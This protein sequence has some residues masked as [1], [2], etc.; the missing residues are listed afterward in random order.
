MTSIDTTE[1]VEVETGTLKF[2]N[3]TQQAKFELGTCMAV[4]KWE[5]LATAVENSWGGAN[6]AEKRD[7]IC[8][9]IIDLFA[10]SKAVDVQLIEETLLYAMLDEFDTE[11]DNDSGLEIAALVM[12]FYKQV[13]EQ[14][15]DEIA[16]LYAKWLEKKERGVQ[17]HHVHVQ[18]DP[19]NPDVSDNE[20][21]E[22]VENE[23]E[24]EDMAIDIDEP[25]LVEHQSAELGPIVDDDGFE[26]VQKGGRRSK[27]RR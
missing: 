12:K 21:E 6:S 14:K 17:N 20:G 23:A 1:F 26:L 10:E 11:V 19:N 7:W 24:A 8:G 25:E 16:Q 15:Y 13:S 9:V 4:Y 18:E 22:E 3:E 27:S 5:E 2:E